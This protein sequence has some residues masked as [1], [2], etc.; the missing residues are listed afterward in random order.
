MT[1][2]L[3]TGRL[4]RSGE[5]PGEQVIHRSGSGLAFRLARNGDHDGVAADLVTGE[6]AMP[7][8]SRG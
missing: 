1:G 5:S 3:E 2:T 6:D 4:R 7:A 8:T